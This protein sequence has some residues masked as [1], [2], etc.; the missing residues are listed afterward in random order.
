MENMNHNIHGF[1]IQNIGDADIPYLLYNG[2]DEHAQNVI[3][4]HATGFPPQLW[5][6]VAVKLSQAYRV[7][8]LLYCDHREAD[9]KTEAVNWMTL[10]N[11]L[12]QICRK[13]N[14]EKPFVAGHSMGA[15]V[16]ALSEAACGL[17][18]A[19]LVLIEPIFLIPELYHIPFTVYD[20]PF[21]SKSIKRI[22]YWRDEV[23]LRQYLKS[24]TLFQRWDSDILELYIKYGFKKDQE[25]G[26]RLVCSPQREAE[27]F[28]GGM[29]YD[30]WSLFPQI[31]CPVLVLE[32]ENSEN[33]IYA[34]LEKACS[35][36]PQGSYLRTVDAGHLIPMEKPNEMADII[37]DYIQGIQKKSA[38]GIPSKKK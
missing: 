5:H 36:M 1:L 31:H 32:G 13:L 27:L 20:H 38:E 25:G 33:R 24:R 2:P 11:D 12:A 7:I 19:A 17:D 16:A 3:L 34:A 22:D 10:A 29:K 4:L 18:A 21:A 28:M 37:M 6:P 23:E 8:A 9:S 15:T 14:I 30:P 35:L 26:M